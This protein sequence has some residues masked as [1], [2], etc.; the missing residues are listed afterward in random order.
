MVKKITYLWLS[1]AS[2]RQIEMLTLFDLLV[3]EYIVIN[4]FSESYEACS[5]MKRSLSHKLNP[6]RLS[7]VTV[8]ARAVIDRRWR[9]AV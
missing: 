2:F 1:F 6:E 7:Q 8:E 9:L 3:N 4:F 5:L